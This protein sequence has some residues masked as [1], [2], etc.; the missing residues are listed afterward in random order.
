M[1]ADL[2]LF[3]ELVFLHCTFCSQKVISSSFPAI[4]HD[5]LYCGYILTD[6]LTVFYGRN[7]EKKK[8]EK[9]GA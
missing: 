8:M 3:V 6:S 2:C 7:H 4:R 1:T 9:M 5:T